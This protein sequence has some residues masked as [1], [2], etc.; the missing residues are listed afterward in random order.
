MTQVSVKILGYSKF[1]KV[2][3]IYA[4]GSVEYDESYT[5]D[6][7]FKYGGGSGHN[8]GSNFFKAYLLDSVVVQINLMAEDQFQNVI[9]EVPVKVVN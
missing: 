4:L 5:I 1:L 9:L 6:K 7:S 3:D 8:R 2:P